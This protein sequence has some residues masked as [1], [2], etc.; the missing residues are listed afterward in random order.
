MAVVD[1]G[2]TG[3]F[4][5]PG[6]PVIDVLPTSRPISI[7]LPNSSVIKSTHTCRINIPW[8]PER[9]TRAHIVPGLAHTSLIPIASLCNAGCRVIYDG[10]KCKVYFENKVTWRGN[11]E[12]STKLWVLPLEPRDENLEQKSLKE[13]DHQ[14]NFITHQANNT[15]IMS[16]KES[17]IK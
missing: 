8:L 10:D 16:Y 5:L 3:H 1:A 4:V 6:T 12:P 2:A 17:L 14:A 11:R 7:N 13:Q 15:Y 9:A